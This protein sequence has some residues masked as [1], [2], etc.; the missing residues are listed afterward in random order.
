MTADAVARLGAGESAAP[1]RGEPWHGAAK[2]EA[3]LGEGSYADAA[4]RFASRYAAFDP[5][6]QREA[7]LER[8]EALLAGGQPPPAAEARAR[9]QA[10]G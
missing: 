6:R 3:V 7:M 4:G 1:R 8:A 5:A 2:L 10:V 9:L